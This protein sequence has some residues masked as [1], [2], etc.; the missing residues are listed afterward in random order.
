[1]LDTNICIFTIKNKPSTVRETFRQCQDQLCISSV[2]FMELMYGTERSA[3]PRENLAVVEG[4][5]ARLTV[6]DYDPGAA[7]HTGQLRAELARAG[8]PIGPYDQMIA[9][10]ARSLGLILVTHNTGEFERVP[11]LRIEDWLSQ[12]GA[13]ESA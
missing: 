11:G 1:M 9:G 7:M 13:G 6:L 3:R 5:A 2:T 8:T 4:F 10:H 12:P